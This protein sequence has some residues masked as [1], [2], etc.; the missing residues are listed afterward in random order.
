MD[1]VGVF[2]AMYTGM[3]P[4]KQRGELQSLA[5]INHFSSTQG[6]VNLPA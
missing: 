2:I 6:M 4:N 5:Y 1:P 3:T